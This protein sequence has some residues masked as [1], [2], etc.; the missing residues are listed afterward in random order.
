WRLYHDGRFDEAGTAFGRALAGD[1]RSLPAL[2]GLGWSALRQKRTAMAKPYFERLLALYPEHPGALD[3]L[4]LCLRAE[5]DTQAAVK[6]WERLVRYEPLT[7]GGFQHG[8][9]REL[10]AV[11]A[12]QGDDRRAL[13]YLARAVTRNPRDRE[14]LKLLH[15]TAGRLLS[16]PQPPVP[17]PEDVRPRLD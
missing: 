11:Y 10:G 9:F 16:S 3:G 1:P 15:R 14:A 6:I 8:A 7:P 2:D 13:P 4:A 17:L 5:G 12:A